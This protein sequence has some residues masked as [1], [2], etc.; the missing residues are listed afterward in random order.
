MVPP[1]SSRVSRVPLYSGYC[2]VLESFVYRAFTVFGWL[3]QSHSTTLLQSRPQSATPNLRRGL[4]WPVTISLAATLVID[5]SFSSCRYL[6]V[7]VH[8][9]YLYTP[10]YSVH[11]DWAFPSRVSPFGYPRITDC[12]RLHAAFRS[13][14]RP[15][16]APSAKASSRCSFLLDLTCGLVNYESPCI[17]PV[18]LRITSSTHPYVPK[19]TR[20]ISSHRS[21]NKSS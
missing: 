10:I 1:A 2:C 16:S 18:F 8:D 21:A 14:L 7:S 17:F 3:S 9:V 4:V 11:S 6:D 15:S 12:V 13:F 20:R 19:G 5:F